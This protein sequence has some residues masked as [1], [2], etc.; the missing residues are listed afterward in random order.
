MRRLHGVERD[1]TGIGAAV[2]AHELRSRALAPDLELF[3]RGGAERVGGREAHLQPSET[4]RFASLPI[5]VVLPAPFTPTTMT[6]PGAPLRQVQ[7]LVLS[8][9]A[10]DL[11]GE[12]LHGVGAVRVVGLDALHEVGRGGG[13]DIGLDQQVLE[14]LPRL[15]R[16][17]P[18]C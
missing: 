15:R 14:F 6:T 10:I 1:R 5:V 18:P 4:S 3:A 13:T 7:R 8:E 17:Q 12:Q 9:D 2:L 11:G 16:R